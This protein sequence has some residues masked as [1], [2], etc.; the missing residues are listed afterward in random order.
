[1]IRIIVDSSTM[2]TKKEGKDMGIYVTPL[3]VTI[4]GK[5][6]LEFEEIN[7]EEFV[8]IIN[9]G[10]YPKSSQPVVGALKEIL[11]QDENIDTIILC[12]ADGLSG[13]YSSTVGL[14][15]TL[16]KNDH[17]R[18][19]NSKTLCGPIRYMVK[20][21]VKM[22]NDG[23]S[24]DDILNRLELFSNNCHSYLIPMNFDYLKR[25]GR[26]TPIAATLG[27]LLKLYP[28]MQTINGGTKI[29]K[30]AIT[31]TFDSSINKIVECMKKN[32]IDNRYLVTISHAFNKKQADI[33]Y[34][35]IQDAFK[36]IEIKMYELSCAFITQGGPSCIAIQYILK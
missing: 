17:I 10:H 25:G 24:I 33:A 6:Y 26:L 29:D 3:Q 1:M 27:G 4:D 19:V 2:F 31:R 11:L 13:T 12:I 22:N 5:T 15:S 9:K 20:E 16:D 28:L 7:A 36:D 23:K 21:I 32:N 34:Q 30:L 14:V 8:N 18:V 35:I